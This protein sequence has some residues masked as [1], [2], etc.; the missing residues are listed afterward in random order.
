MCKYMLVGKNQW[1]MNNAETALYKDSQEPGALAAS[2]NR[3]WVL[4]ED[5]NKIFAWT[6]ITFE[7]CKCITY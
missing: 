3:K 5:K 7:L 4:L 2:G 6:L 1:V